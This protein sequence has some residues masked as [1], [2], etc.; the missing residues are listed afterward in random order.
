[1]RVT[2]SENC[3]INLCADLRVWGKIFV[4]EILMRNVSRFDFQYLNATQYQT[5]LIICI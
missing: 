3:S 5:K 2:L 1:M 4:T